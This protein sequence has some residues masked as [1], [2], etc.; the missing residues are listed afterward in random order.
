MT[1]PVATSAFSITAGA[2]KAWSRRSGDAQVTAWICGD[3]GVRIYGERDTRPDSLNIRPG[4][5][6]DTSW[7]RPAAHIFMRSAQP[8]EHVADGSICFETWPDDFKATM[9]AWRTR[10]G[11]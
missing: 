4:T 2:P 6:D 8:W 7:L 3:C 5:L 1:M 11:E 10:W 9:Q